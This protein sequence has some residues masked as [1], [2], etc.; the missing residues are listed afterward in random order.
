MARLFALSFIWGWSFLFSQVA[1]Q[2]LTPSAVAAGRTGLGAVVLVIVLRLTRTPVPRDRRSLLSL[3]FVGGDEL[4][5]TQGLAV[6]APVLAG[7]F[8]GLTFCVAARNLMG[9][10][11]VVA[12]TG[13]V[14]GATLLLAPLAIATTVADGQVP[15]PRQIGSMLALGSVGTGVAYLLSFRI[16]ADL[17]PTVASLSTYLIPVVALVVGGVVLDEHI[18]PRL[19]V[20]GAITVAAVAVVTRARPPA[21]RRGAL[22][23]VAPDGGAPDPQPER[24]R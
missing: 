1:G 9:I 12:A 16:I 10:P 7:F 15:G 24:S 19:V 6:M 8:Y 14:V 21:A 4:S 2:D 5:G 17:G 20:G 23:A 3:L 22:A 18:T 13:Q 11:P